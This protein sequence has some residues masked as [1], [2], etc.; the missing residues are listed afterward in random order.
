[1]TGDPASETWALNSHREQGR[2]RGGPKEGFPR[3]DR[4]RVHL[5]LDPTEPVGDSSAPVTD[6]PVDEVRRVQG[7]TATSEP[8]P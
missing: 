4:L 8:V 1:M 7:G 3:K 6:P 2:V 5:A